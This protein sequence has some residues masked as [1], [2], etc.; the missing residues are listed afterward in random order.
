MFLFVCLLLFSFWFFVCLFVF[1]FLE[2]NVGH[3]R[4]VTC[5]C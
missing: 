1:G 4:N 5:F 3:Y 2:A